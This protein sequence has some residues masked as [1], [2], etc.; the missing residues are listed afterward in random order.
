MSLINDALKR[1]RQ[2]T[3]PATPGGPELQPAE[4]GEKPR[5]G[6]RGGGM[7][8][9]A[10]VAALLA[11]AL[12]KLSA[13]DPAPPPL[14]GTNTAVRSIME[15]GQKNTNAPAKAPPAVAASP[16]PSSSITHTLTNPFAQTAKL[17]NAIAA[18]AQAEP[19]P[20]KTPAPRETT[21]SVA[22]SPEPPSP[23]ASTTT[24]PAQ[25]VT[26]PSPAAATPAPK[27][28]AKPAETLETAA[29]APV[30]Q[31]GGNVSFPELQL[32]GI[33]YRIS[34]PSALINGK[35]VFV[36]DEVSGVRVVKIERRS[37]DVELRGR[38]KTISR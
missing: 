38:I 25:A 13:P 30:V 2:R 23:A 22:A 29:A 3:K 34:K 7:V 35:S 32:Q 19:E 15:A 9:A 12:W 36:G 31:S 28:A 1:T 37:V 27:P 16:A 5:G 6:G 4:P 26:A 24:P 14:G 18:R 17:S 20:A 11:L 8:K 33:F 21:A 10:L